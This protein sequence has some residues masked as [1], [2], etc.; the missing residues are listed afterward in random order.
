MDLPTPDFGASSDLQAP[1]LQR[2]EIKQSTRQRE[3]AQQQDH[4]HLL[5][6]RGFSYFP[7]LVLK[8]IDFTGWKYALILCTG[9]PYLPEFPMQLDAPRP[10]NRML[11]TYPFG[12]PGGLQRVN[13][14]IFWQGPVC[15]LALANG[16]DSH[17]VLSMCA[18]RARTGVLSVPHCFFFQPGVGLLSYCCRMVGCSR[19]TS[20]G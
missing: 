12:P 11:R 6:H 2:R 14:C 16:V 9:F 15:T 4:F 17:E 18:E 8:G 1:V 7:L 10:C 5:Q 13:S 19:V 20:R 3:D